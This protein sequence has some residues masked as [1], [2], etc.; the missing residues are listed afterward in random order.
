MSIVIGIRVLVYRIKFCFY[1]CILIP[2]DNHLKDGIRDGGQRARWLS[3][4]VSDSKA[5][6]G[7]SI[8]TSAVLC[9]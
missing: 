4:R 7:G 3:G 2:H 5:R 1:F 9:S 6:V 8:P